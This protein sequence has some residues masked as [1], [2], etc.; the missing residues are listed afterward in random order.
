MGKV[1]A[2]LVERGNGIQLR[3][4]TMPET[5]DLGKDEPD[6]VADLPAGAELVERA[7]VDA[8]LGSDEPIQIVRLGHGATAL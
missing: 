3:R 7:V 8:L 5:R 1:S 6:P 4:G 2:R